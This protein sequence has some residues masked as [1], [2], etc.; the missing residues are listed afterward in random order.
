MISE[1]Q[2]RR[3]ILI[4]EDELDFAEILKTYCEELKIFRNIVIAQDGSIGLNKLNNQDFLLGIFDLN[5]PK[6][7]GIQLLHHL[8][9]STTQKVENALVISG[10]I[11]P[12]NVEYAYDLG[13]RQFLVKP[14]SKEQFYEKIINVLLRIAP[15]IKN[16]NVP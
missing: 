4:V 14:F 1:F 15:K 16:F 12:Q 10:E 3:D 5:L 13:V 6:K 2:N 11:A 9:S 8:K 7:N